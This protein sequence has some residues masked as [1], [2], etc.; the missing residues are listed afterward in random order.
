MTE[1]KNKN[2]KQQ[3]KLK[4]RLIETESVKWHFS[5]VR[6]EKFKW[7]V[8]GIWFFLKNKNNKTKQLSLY[9][10]KFYSARPQIN[11]KGQK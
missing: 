11:L 6:G 10:V 2:R 8:I 7:S 1:L 5:I 4:I 9:E 3:Q